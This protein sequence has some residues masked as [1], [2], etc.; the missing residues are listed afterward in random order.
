[1]RVKV[2]C[3]ALSFI[4]YSLTYIITLGKLIIVDKVWLFGNCLKQ[5]VLLNLA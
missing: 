3:S 5:A 2:F 1:M 4:W